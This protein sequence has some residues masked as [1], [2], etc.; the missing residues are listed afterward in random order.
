[1]PPEY[2]LLNHSQL[3]LLVLELFISLLNFVEMTLSGGTVSK[4][5]KP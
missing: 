4:L 3:F 2:L 5:E 1:M